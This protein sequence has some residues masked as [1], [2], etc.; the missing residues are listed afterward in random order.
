MIINIITITIKSKSVKSLLLYPSV[1]RTFP[2]KKMV[3]CGMFVCMVGIRNIMTIYWCPC[4][5]LAFRLL[6]RKK[7]S[8]CSISN[9]YNSMI[10]LVSITWLTVFLKYFW[11]FSFISSE[12]SIYCSLQSI[13][14]VERCLNLIRL[15]LWEKTLKATSLQL[16]TFLFLVKFPWPAFIIF[17]LHSTSVT[18]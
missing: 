2:S 8:L 5:A 4:I 7:A 1:K 3:D 17:Y 18:L 6:P 9:F 12:L 10:I 16:E 15:V 11:R 14:V 13:W